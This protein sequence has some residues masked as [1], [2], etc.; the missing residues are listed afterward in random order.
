MHD[1]VYIV[2]GSPAEQ[3]V[4]VN[5]VKELPPET[6]EAGQY[7]FRFMVITTGAGARFSLRNDQ[8]GF[9]AGWRHLAKDGADLLAH[10]QQATGA[11]VDIA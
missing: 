4:V 5:G 10:L 2:G 6:L 11:E 7:R 9:L 8:N 1:R 3:G